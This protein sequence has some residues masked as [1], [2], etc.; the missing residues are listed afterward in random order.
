MNARMT[1]LLRDESPTAVKGK[2]TLT[3]V[4]MLR[5][6]VSAAFAAA[7]FCGDRVSAQAR[8]GQPAAPAPAPAAPTPTPAAPAKGPGRVVILGFDGV[9]PS[10]VDAMLAAGQLPNLAKLRDQGCYERLASSNPPQ[11]PTAWS[12]FAT[13]KNPGN[14]G[15]YDFLRRNPQDYTPGLGF[16]ITKHPELAPDGAL[17]KPAE[18]MNYRKGDTF[19]SVANRQGMRCKLL[20]VP[21]AYPVEHLESS[22][23]LCGL[24]VPDIRGTQS[25][26][27]ALS[28]QFKEQESVPGGVKLP[29]KFEGD[30]ATAMVPGVRHPET[31]EFVGVPMKVI[32]DRQ[33]HTVAIDL[34]GQ[35]AKL[36]ENTWSPWLE[37]TF[38]VTPKFSVRAI[39]RIHVLE[40]GERVRLYMTCLQIHPRA[41]YLPIS[42]PD[43]FAVKLADRYGL[44]KTVGW[45]YDTKALQQSEMTEDMFLDDARKTMA[46]NET[47]LLDEM[48]LNAFDLLIAGWT[49]TDRVAHMFW[50]FRDPKHPLYTAEGA[51]K[52]GRAVEET[53][54]KMDEIVGKAMAKIAPNDLVIVLSDHGFHSFRKAF[55]LNT[56]LVRTGYLAVKGQSDPAT[57][58]TNK[59]Y[60]EDYDWSKSR[61]YGLGLGSVFLNLKGR[62]GQGTVAPE[63]AP[64]LLAEIKGKLLALTDPQTGDKVFQAVYLK[65]D[66]YKGAS[67][68]EAPDIQLGYADGYQTDKA[69]AAGA[70][71]QELLSSN[72][73]K[74]SG[75]HAASDVAITPGIFFSNKPLA[76]SAAII[77]IGPTALKYLGAQIPGD[78]EGKSL[79]P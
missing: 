41:P 18:Y 65:A 25:T 66:A 12:S 39:S 69:S 67:E 42:V 56:W 2:T 32:V 8:A 15:I 13:C 70:A 55:S 58:F 16:G 29:L 14:H 71:P 50:R 9:E 11:S 74:W 73:D 54:A 79:L 61:A 27:F 72:D 51:Q 3:R 28:D 48:D 53:Y 26:Y 64:A 68:V 20:I 38:E 43:D 44:F 63:D 45:A 4:L 47:L 33:G 49:A 22:E 10:I 35:T 62:E 7:L 46:W 60:L 75:E 34:Q 36:A 1:G 19:W 77:D 40:A 31:K 57:A 6:L 59:K 76:P 23:M 30:T 21:F 24:D 37:W 17:S 5:M 78:F 52:Y